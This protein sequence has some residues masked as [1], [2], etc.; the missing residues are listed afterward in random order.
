MGSDCADEAQEIGQSVD[1]DAPILSDIRD[2]IDNIGI[3][4][5]DAVVVLGKD[6]RVKHAVVS[7]LRPGP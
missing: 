4:V 5:D 3:A 6:A 2:S 1:I 7:G